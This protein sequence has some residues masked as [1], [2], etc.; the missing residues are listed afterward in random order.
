MYWVLKYYNLKKLIA[1]R[2]YGLFCESISRFTCQT[3]LT[4]TPWTTFGQCLSY[5]RFFVCILCILTFF[6]YIGNC[7]LCAILHVYKITDFGIYC[8]WYFCVCQWKKLR[9]VVLCFSVLYFGIPCIFCTFDF[10]LINLMWVFCA[11]LFC[12]WNFVFNFV[13]S[14]TCALHILQCKIFAAHSKCNKKINHLF[15]LPQNSLRIFN[16]QITCESVC[17]QTNKLK[18]ALSPSTC[19]ARTQDQLSLSETSARTILP[20]ALDTYAHPYAW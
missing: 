14:K 9:E 2:P 18:S 3:S 16:P 20:A 5:T 10:F 15:F 4:I 17:K 7:L 8:N 6:L 11:L 19:P 1:K 12:V 13:C